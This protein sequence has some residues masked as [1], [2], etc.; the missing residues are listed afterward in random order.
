MI[1]SKFLQLAF[2]LTLATLVGSAYAVAQDA[3]LIK[4][5]ETPPAQPAPPVDGDFSKIPLDKIPP[6]VIIVKGAAPS[7]S[8][9]STPLPEGGF[10]SKKVF[11]IVTSDGPI[12]ATDGGV[13]QMPSPSETG[14][15]TCSRISS[16]PRA[17]SV[18]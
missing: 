7:A 3:P 14:S 8:D 13:L 5:S 17:A 6:G 1:R 18:P 4:G 16:H 11:R 15:D 12:P 10:V 9:R 2:L